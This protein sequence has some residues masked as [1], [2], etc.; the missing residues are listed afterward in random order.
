MSFKIG[1]YLKCPSCGYQFWAMLWSIHYGKGE[2]CPGCG[3]H[4][5]WRL[6][7]NYAYIAVSGVFLILIA[8]RPSLVD[9]ITFPGIL[10]IVLAVILLYFPC[11]PL[12]VVPGSEAVE[13]AP[14][15]V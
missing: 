9:K 1:D 6:A 15:E 7:N 3:L 10:A 11:V 13:K 2:R 8:S 14:E 12:E 4:I 5:R